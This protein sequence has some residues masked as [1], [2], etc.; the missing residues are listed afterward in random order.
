MEKQIILA[1]IE[2]IVKSL[3]LVLIDLN[4]RGDHNLQVIEVYI[5]GEKGIDTDICGTVSRAIDEAIE[6][7]NLVNSN[8]RL[9]VSSPGV[10]RPLKYLIQYHKHINRKFEVEFTDQ[11]GEKK[12]KGKLLR[13][14]GED[15]YFLEEK[16]EYRINF[17]KIVK[18]KVII[19]F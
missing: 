8:Y 13:I 12:L 6:K 17:N 2:E 10:D 15:L 14:E 4:L 11:E 7:E 1:R 5:D 19:S 9:D 3:G 18:A 16:A